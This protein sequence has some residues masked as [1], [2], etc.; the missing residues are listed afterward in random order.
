MVDFNREPPPAKYRIN[1]DRARVAYDA[2]ADT[3]QDLYSTR[4][5][6]GGRRTVR[7]PSHM[8]N[9]ADV[10]PIIYDDASVDVRRWWKGAPDERPA[11]THRASPERQPDIARFVAPGEVAISI[12]HHAPHPEPKEAVKLQCTHVQ[13]VIGVQLDGAGGAITLNNPQDY[14]TD[15]GLFGTEVYPMIFVK[16]RFPNAVSADSARR[17]VDNIRTWAVIANTYSE[18]PI[19]NYNGND[20]LATRTVP[21]V[22]AFG[23]KLLDAITG[24]VTPLTEAARQAE[25]LCLNTLSAV[26]AERASLRVWLGVYECFSPSPDLEDFA[27]F[28]ENPQ[29]W[30][31]EAKHVAAALDGSSSIAIPY[32]LWTVDV[33]S[34]DILPLDTLAKD[35]AEDSCYHSPS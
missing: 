11:P 18:F 31:I 25:R 17:Y 24:E 29:Q 14:H 3:V 6:M 5:D 19:G 34:G 9:Q 1:L 35:T 12:K 4:V 15:V 10:R 33:A 30:I 26:T 28:Q 27:S 16:P 20:P 13:I 21:Q 32:G 8:L 7:S 2:T 22:E 23:T